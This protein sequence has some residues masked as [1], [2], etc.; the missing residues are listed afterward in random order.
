[1]KNQIIV[2][3]LYNNRKIDGSIINAFEYFYTLYELKIPIELLIYTTYNINEL[4]N[5]LKA[6]YNID[7]KCLELIK[8][9]KNPELLTGKTL[10]VDGYSVENLPQKISKRSE[11]L[12]IPGYKHVNNPNVKYFRVFDFLFDSGP[13]VQNYNQALRLDLFKYCKPQSGI[14]VNSPHNP[15]IF[16]ESHKKIYRR[17]DLQCP[18]M[19]QYFDEMVYIQNSEIVD[20]K[21]RSF[22]ECQY[23]GIPYTYI[24]K[25]IK[26]GSYFRYSDYN[27]IKMDENDLIIKEF[28]NGF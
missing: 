8:P 4:I 11:I 3:Y 18:N 10:L 21:P 25:G 13:N 9:L 15:G 26:D 12:A 28:L 23:F 7:Y 1:M 16:Y 20:R 24:F 19:Y 22:W 27:I 2:S 14:F 5:F 6:K 17:E